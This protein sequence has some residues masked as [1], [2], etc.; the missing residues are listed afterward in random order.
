MIR[1]CDKTAFRNPE[2]EYYT[3]ILGRRWK[4]KKPEQ[5]EEGSRFIEEN[6]R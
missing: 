3:D 2:P 1:L 6:F 5:T 4:K